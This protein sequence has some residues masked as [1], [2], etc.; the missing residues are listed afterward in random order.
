MKRRRSQSGNVMLEFAVGAGVMVAVFTG[1]FVFGYNFYRYNTLA[2]AVASGAEYASLRPYDSST[3]T[4]S[5]AFLTAVQN[6]VVFGDPSGTATTPVSPGLTKDNVKLTVTFSS[7][8]AGKGV[9]VTVTVYIANYTLNAIFGKNTYDQK[10]SVTYA[11]S[12]VYSPF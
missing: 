7:A 10:P 3:T 8:T 5:S 6:M 2:T 9:P 1:T 4:P 11:Y 12:G